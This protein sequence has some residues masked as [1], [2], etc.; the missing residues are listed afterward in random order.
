MK[1]ATTEYL[2]GVALIEKGSFDAAIECL[3]KAIDKYDD[4]YQ[5]YEKRALAHFRAGRIE[6]ALV[7]YAKSLALFPNSEALLGQAEVKA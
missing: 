1:V 3:N 5:A 2:K 7:D 6:D 4:Y